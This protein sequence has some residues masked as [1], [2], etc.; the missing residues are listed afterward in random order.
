MALTM[1]KREPRALPIFILVDTSGSMSGAKIN[2]LNSALRDMVHSL[3]EVNDIPGKFQ[4]A[5]ITFGDTVNYF[6]ELADVDKIT[7]SELTANGCTPMGQAFEMV[8]ELI[9]DKDK[10]SSRAYSPTIVLLS[11]GLPTDCPS[12]I[13]NTKSYL[14]WEPLKALHS[15]E[16]SKKCLRLALGI[17]GDADHEMLEA[18]INNSEVPVITTKD[19]SGISKFFKWVTMSTIS[20]MS[21]VNPNMPLVLP[22]SD[23]YNPNDEGMHV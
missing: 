21:S 9:E 17:G 12:Q 16:R 22:T 19:A 5:I 8:K 18:F 23:V 13:F 3:N 7:L 6:Q 20:R 14:D 10:V 2:A 1:A 4:L 15:G 11:D